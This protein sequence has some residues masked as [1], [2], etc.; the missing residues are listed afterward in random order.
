MVK[1]G[2][3]LIILAVVGMMVIIVLPV[4]PPLA[5]NATIDQL[6]QPLICQPGETIQRE[7]YSRST[8][9]GTNYSMDV[10][11]LDRQEHRRDE[12]GRWVLIGAVAFTIPLLIGLFMVIGASR[13]NL[14]ARIAESPMPGAAD[15][16]P[17]LWAARSGAPARLT[18]TQRLKE[19]EEAHEAGHLSDLEYKLIRKKILDRMDD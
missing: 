7:L 11:C 8:G 18:L 10:Y 14:A 1:L 16:Q 13:R 19:L 4:L 5:D 2:V 3:L 17:S 15:A 9:D 12:T 6:L